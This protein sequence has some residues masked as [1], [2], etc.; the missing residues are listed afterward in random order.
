M[1]CGVGLYAAEI[2]AGLRET[3]GEIEFICCVPYE[4]QATKWTPELRNR[5]FNVLAASTDVVY[6]GHEKAVG[7]E[8]KM[9][10]EAAKEADTVIVVYDP[11]DLLCDREAAAAAVAEVLNKQ[12]L[13]V[14]FLCDNAFHSL[15]RFLADDMLHPA[16]VFLGSFRAYAKRDEQLFQDTMLFINLLRRGAPRIRQ[17]KAFL[18]IHRQKTAFAEKLHRPADAGLGHLQLFR[19][20]QRTNRPVPVLQDQ[21]RLQIILHRSGQT[22]ESATSVLH[23]GEGEL[24]LFNYIILYLTGL[25]TPCRG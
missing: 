2:L 12:I 13:T 21:D 18:F 19:D 8:F 6:S 22:H 3:D 11:D 7:C 25:S 15:K 5:Y 14:L 9:H 1:D 16:G 4:E 24:V 20:I 23:P 17:K 10:L